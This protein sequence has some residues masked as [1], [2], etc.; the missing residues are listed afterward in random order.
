M[1]CP[2][3]DNKGVGERGQQSCRQQNNEA[4]VYCKLQNR[5]QELQHKVIK[6]EILKYGGRLL[7]FCITCRDA[8]VSTWSDGQNIN[9]P[10]VGRKC[11]VSL[12]L[13]SQYST[14]AVA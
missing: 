4:A 11:D 14:A 3:A 7:Y 9:N 12:A 13:R 2:D 10:L 8:D 6:R 1:C 5:N